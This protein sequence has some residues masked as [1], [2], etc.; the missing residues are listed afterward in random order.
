MTTARA[1]GARRALP[2][3]AD[4]PAEEPVAEDG[5]RVHA[6]Q[7]LLAKASAAFARAKHVLLA[8]ATAAIDAGIASLQRLR[9]RAGGAEHRHERRDRERPGKRATT[10][11]PRGE[12]AAEE[13]IAPKP[14]RRLRGLLVYLGVMLAGGM[15]G[16][17]LA[18]DLLAQ[19]LDRRSAE[20]GRQEVKLSKY[21]KS[22]AELK[23][24]LDRQQAK[25]IE[26]ETRL[27]T[28]L[29]QNEKK[30]GEL[31]AQRAE[32]ETRLASALAGRANN[33]QRREDIG[34][35][36]GAARSG[37]AGWTRSGD[38]TLGSG[39]IRSVL[40]GCIAEMNRK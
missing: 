31:Q 18:Y 38:C 22:V 10:E 17:A 30:L 6:R 39:D 24:K 15:L 23:K 13:T 26:A 12:R 40:N 8:A 9:K 32:A 21:S 16:M 37:R 34:G 33:P 19:L 35:S 3:D 4:T 36:R 5:W 11:R 28:A 25:Q 14:R 27:A 1:P 20:I 7:W 29:A 2:R